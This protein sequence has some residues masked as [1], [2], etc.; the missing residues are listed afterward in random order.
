MNTAIIVAAGSGT[1]FQSET[2]KQYLDLAGIP[3]LMHSIRAFENCDEI[4]EIILAVNTD[5]DEKLLASR[6]TLKPIKHIIGGN[7]RLESVIKA[8][9]AVSSDT[10]IVVIH[11]GVRPMVTP[12]E[13]K[14][15]IKA[16]RT[17]G[18]ACLTAPVTDTIKRVDGET[19]VSTVDRMELRRA[20]TPQAFNLRLLLSAIDARD[21]EVEFTDESS[22]VEDYGK[23]VA[24]VEG[25]A[26]N[27]K[28]THPQDLLIAEVLLRARN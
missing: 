4:D 25:S 9:E 1:R 24:A 28:I 16:A 18:A 6:L 11:D 2:P 14:A 13:I 15:T 8:L 17:V 10:Q 21:E 3:V 5:F 12:N 19:I 22:I 20:L 26:A 27:I 23:H 7:S